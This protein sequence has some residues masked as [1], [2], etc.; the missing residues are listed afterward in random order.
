[1]FC[2]RVKIIVTHTKRQ[3]V[4]SVFSTIKK[5]KQCKVVLGKQ[6][7]CEGSMK[8]PRLLRLSSNIKLFMYSNV[9]NPVP[10]TKCM[11]RLKFESTW[12]DPRIKFE[13][14]TWGFQW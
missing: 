11:K 2:G 6:N 9:M 13:W 3:E 7:A 10:S 8:M 12:V 14:S 4:W 1:M 5:H